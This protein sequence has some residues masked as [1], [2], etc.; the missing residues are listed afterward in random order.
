MVIVGTDVHKRTHTFVV[1]D[2]AGKQLDS[3]SVVTTSEG[4]GRALA[5]VQERFGTDVLWAIEDCRNM[6]AVLERDLL[7][8]GQRVVRVPPALM[9]EQRR[10]SRTRGKSDPI[11]ALAVA[12]AAAREPDLP[13]ACHD[14]DSREMKLLTDRRETLVARRTAAI[15]SLR[16]RVHEL[17]P[18]HDIPARS[19]DRRVQH[20]ALAQWLKDRDGL[21]AEL[22]RDELDE[23]IAW[24]A[25]INALARRIDTRVAHIAPGLRTVPGCGPLTAAKLVGECAGITR[26]ATSDKFACHAGVAPIPAWSGSS[27][28][29]MR[30][31]R[32]GNRQLNTALHRI[33][34]TQIAMTDSPGRAYYDKRRADGHSARHALRSLKRQLARVVYN[35]LVTD[36]HAAEPPPLT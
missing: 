23:I 26:F 11:D 6:S 9:A 22:A 5:H 2:E 32:S 3:L 28:G 15:N 24:T 10:V 14:A 16:W 29:R 7:T 18:G 35:H 20:T 27:Q 1:I 17:D 19:L 33:A 31:S 12:R 21:I 4:H 34:L 8:A 36:H 25:E 30:L 13:V